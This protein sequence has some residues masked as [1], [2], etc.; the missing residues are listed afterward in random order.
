VFGAVP[1]LALRQGGISA[2]LVT[3][4]AG[5][6]ALGGIG[7]SAL[8]YAGK[9]MTIDSEGVEERVYRLHYN[10]GQQRVD[11]FTAVR[12]GVCVLWGLSCCVGGVGS[13]TMALFC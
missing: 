6:G 3:R 11:S 12:W 8:L 13:C 2:E 9:R 1:I 10:A 5:W 4:G 7:L